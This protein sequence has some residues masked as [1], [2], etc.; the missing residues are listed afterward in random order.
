MDRVTWAQA[1]HHARAGSAVASLWV[2]SRQVPG[3]KVGIGGG[4]FRVPLGRQGVLRK[5]HGVEGYP[6][7]KRSLGDHVGAVGKDDGVLTRGV[8]WRKAIVSG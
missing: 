7:E 1:V 6:P 8:R 2:Q 5:K 3:V 4:K